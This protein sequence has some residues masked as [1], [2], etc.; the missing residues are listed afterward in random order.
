MLHLA[1][2]ALLAAS[3]LADGPDGD[4]DADKNPHRQDVPSAIVGVGGLG[5]VDS[6]VN[7]TYALGPPA[8]LPIKLWVGYAYGEV[9]DIFDGSG[10]DIAS[11][12]PGGFGQ[13][14][15]QRAFVGAQI[16]PI[17]LPNFSIGVGGQLMAAKNE[18]EGIFRQGIVTPSGLV[19]VRVSG[20]SDFGLQNAKVYGVVR[21]RVLGIH[22]GYIFDLGPES[23]ASDDIRA[24]LLA[25]QTDVSI[26]D[27]PNSDEHDAWF[28]GVDFN[29]ASER[30]HI[31]GGIDYF[32]LDT[33]VEP[34]DADAPTNEGETSPELIVFNTGLGI[35]F[36][37]IEIGAA[38]LL[39]TNIVENRTGD[40]DGG[41]QGSIAPY[42]NFSPDAIPFSL[43]VKGAV[44][45]EYA[46]YG[47]SLG[48]NDDFVTELGVTVTAALGF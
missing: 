11:D 38:A 8:D 48:G 32:N 10:N 46:D 4:K 30:F 26:S 23:S 27:Y 2:V 42:I 33:D 7:D 13:L 17:H 9:E 34:G 37:W 15:E 47:Y 39:R 16:M 6:I 31:F 40:N 29:Y 22:G 41:H 25:G 20:E 44:L 21:G 19:N 43:S 18:A 5:Y 36:A 1:L 24:A 28:L 35:R 45:G 14:I 12:I 3:P